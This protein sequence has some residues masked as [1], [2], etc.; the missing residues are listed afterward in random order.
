MRTSNVP[1]GAVLTPKNR[2]RLLFNMAWTSGEQR[3]TSAQATCLKSPATVNWPTL[4][5]FI[6]TKNASVNKASS[7]ET[8]CRQPIGQKV[9]P[10]LCYDTLHI[11]FWLSYSKTPHIAQKH[12]RNTCVCKP[13][14]K[15]TCNTIIAKIKFQK[16]V[17]DIDSNSNNTM[18]WKPTLNYKPQRLTN[19]NEIE[20]S[21]PTNFNNK[22]GTQSFKK[23]IHT[24]P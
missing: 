2:C 7:S 11:M 8:A 5:M 15:N 22:Q 6:K 12:D 21:Q 13:G 4:S 19:L 16:N 17:L 9:N 10:S 3:M 1:L 23:Y 20:K 18:S 24:K 14:S